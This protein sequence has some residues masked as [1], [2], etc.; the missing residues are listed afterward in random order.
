MIELITSEDIRTLF[1]IMNESVDL[2][3]N[4]NYIKFCNLASMLLTGD[5]EPGHSEISQGEDGK[6]FYNR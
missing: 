6:F 1:Q 5:N 4:Y 2:M 3:S